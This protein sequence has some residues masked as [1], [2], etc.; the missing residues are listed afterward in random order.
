MFDVICGQPTD[1]ITELC[2]P[3]VYEKYVT[4]TL[5]DFVRC[6]TLPIDEIYGSKGS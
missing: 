6:V 4:Y 2:I 5:L 3:T 1:N